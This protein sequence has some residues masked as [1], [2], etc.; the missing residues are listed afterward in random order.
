MKETVVQFL[1]NNSIKYIIPIEPKAIQK[2]AK[3]LGRPLS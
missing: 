2:L 1:Y 3:D